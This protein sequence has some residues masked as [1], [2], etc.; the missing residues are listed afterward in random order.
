MR[1]HKLS[2][3]PLAAGSPARGNSERQELSQ[4]VPA[5]FP[6][7][8]SPGLFIRAPLPPGLSPSFA[9]RRLPP[10]LLPLPPAGA[11]HGAPTATAPSCPGL[12]GGGSRLCCESAGF[13][14]LD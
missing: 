5:A 1:A 10:W 12:A 9:H 4:L 7:P 8:S 2:N 6:T 11:S 3:A 13:G 14:V